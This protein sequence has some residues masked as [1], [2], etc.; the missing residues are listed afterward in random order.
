MLAWELTVCMMELFYDLKESQMSDGETKFEMVAPS[1]NRIE[2]VAV[3]SELE[4]KV[5]H[6]GNVVRFDGNRTTKGVSGE[7]EVVAIGVLQFETT[8]GLFLKALSSIVE[9][10]MA[11][12]I[13]ERPLSVAFKMD[14]TPIE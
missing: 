9:W 7:V 12:D 11:N 8:P 1:N 2:F 6:Y 14:A 4:R 5:V 13:A 10:R 3:D